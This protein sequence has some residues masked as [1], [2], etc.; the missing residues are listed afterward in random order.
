MN[1]NAITDLSNINLYEEKTNFIIKHNNLITKISEFENT[2]PNLT[3]F[4]I[5]LLNLK[6]KSY[7][8]CFNIINN[9][10]NNLTLMEDFTKE[11]LI[12]ITYLNNFK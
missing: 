9:N 11:Q 12:L 2:H 8:N 5:K 1:I 3:N 10:I 6:K 4:W 7:E